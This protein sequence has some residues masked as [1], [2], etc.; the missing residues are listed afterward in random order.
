LKYVKV[1]CRSVLVVN[2]S[3]R[4]TDAAKKRM[5]LVAVKGKK[6]ACKICDILEVE[7]KGPQKNKHNCS[8]T[9]FDRP[10]S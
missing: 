7:R 3:K 10:L 8:R 2:N 4:M 5:D 9:D 6:L 1:R